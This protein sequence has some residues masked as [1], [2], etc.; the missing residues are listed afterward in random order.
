VTSKLVLDPAQRRE[1]LV[2]AL[3]RIADQALTPAYRALLAERLRESAYL[4]HQ[5]GKAH[6]ARLASTGAEITQDESVAGRDNPF[7]L[8][9]FEKVVRADSQAPGDDA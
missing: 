8:R 1:Q 4:L 2:E 5:R 7:V 3:A 6:A 9:L